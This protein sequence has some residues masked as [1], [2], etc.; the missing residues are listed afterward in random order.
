[1][2]NVGLNAQVKMLSKQKGWFVNNFLKPKYRF[3][4]NKLREIRN[5]S[6]TELDYLQMI[7]IKQLKFQH[8]DELPK[9]IDY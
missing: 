7:Q 6:T 2:Q 3:S 8:P 4:Q 9:Y 5:L 1:M